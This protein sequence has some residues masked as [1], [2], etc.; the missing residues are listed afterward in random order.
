VF[1]V[2][3]TKMYINRGVHLCNAILVTKILCYRYSTI[4]NSATKNIFKQNLVISLA[5][6]WVIIV[7]NFI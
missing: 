4:N 7:E 6:Y 5:I 1:F 2:G 3:V